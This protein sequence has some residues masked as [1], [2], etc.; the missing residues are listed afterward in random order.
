MIQ[1][2]KVIQKIRGKDSP[3]KRTVL[4]EV[5]GKA[6]FV[7][8]NLGCV[9]IHTIQNFIKLIERRCMERL[10]EEILKTNKHSGCGL[11]IMGLLLFIFK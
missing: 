11:D 9:C 10:M 3:T 2:I 8:R 7:K 4:L 6:I 5:G 1:K